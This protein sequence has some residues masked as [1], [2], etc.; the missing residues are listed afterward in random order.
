MVFGV[1]FESGDGMRLSVGFARVGFAIAA[2]VIAVSISAT[3]VLAGGFAIREQSAS[4]LGSA[5]AGSAAGYDLSSMFWNPAAV[6][7]K[8][9]L[10][11]E[12]HYSILA[13]QTELRDGTLSGP[14]VGFV[15]AL[16][17]LPSETNLDAIAALGASYL[18]YEFA[19]GAFLGLSITSPF[20]LST[21]PD[22]TNWAGFMHGRRA[23]IFTINVNAVAGYRVAPGVTVAAGPMFQYMRATLKFAPAPVP[24]IGS[25]VI[26]AD[27]VGIGFTAGI[28]VQ[29]GG[30][31][32]GLGFR[33]KVKQDLTGSFLV[34]GGGILTAARVDL[35]TPETVTASLRQVVMPGVRLLGTVE[36]TNWSRT[37][38]LIVRDRNSTFFAA[39]NNVITELPL[40]W[41][42]GW[43]FSGGLEYDYSDR[44]TLRGGVAYEISPVD[45]PT[46]RIVQLPDTDRLWVSLGASY[47]WSRALTIDVGYSHV[48]VDD[49]QIQQTVIRNF[50]G[51]GNQPVTLNATSEASVDIISVSMKMKLGGRRALPEPLK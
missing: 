5:F 23:Q 38:T 37:K 40:N 13:L 24:G 42:D 1:E 26:R 10:N 44:L 27:D 29:K 43:F 11:S 47:K 3:S 21:K 49:A 22:D 36:W 8:S 45:D 30:T 50:G 4:G 35:V 46:K 7:V 17:G 28:L 9:G 48:F 18:N 16:A 19:P 25:A 41:S 14:A 32:L 31:S 2:G 12:S 33:S 39:T 34:N 51:L 20:G 6:G 15:P